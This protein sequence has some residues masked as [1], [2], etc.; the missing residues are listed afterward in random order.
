[1]AGLAFGSFS[2][3]R[4]LKQRQHQTAQH[5]ERHKLSEAPLSWPEKSMNAPKITPSEND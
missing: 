4:R 3:Y 1:M 5:K 2:K